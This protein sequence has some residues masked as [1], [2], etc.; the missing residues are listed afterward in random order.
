MFHFLDLRKAHELG[1]ASVAGM[2]YQAV[3]READKLANYIVISRA[4]ESKRLH[5][6][7]QDHCKLAY[8]MITIPC[9]LAQE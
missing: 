4:L 1:P 6:D 3:S 2:V 9:L 5:I 7:N 8:V